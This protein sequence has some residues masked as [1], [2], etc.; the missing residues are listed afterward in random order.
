MIIGS[1]ELA[2]CG[3]KERSLVCVDCRAHY[4]KAG[5]LPAVS[6][7]DAPYLFR[8]VQTESPDGSPGR[9]RTRNK[10]KE[11]VSAF[12]NNLTTRWI[13][14][15]PFLKLLTCFIIYWALKLSLQLTL[16]MKWL[17]QTL[18]LRNHIGVGSICVVWTVLWSIIFTIIYAHC[19]RFI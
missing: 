13:S 1:R 6:R 5:T 18:S 17:R 15:K 4:A 16:I 12:I 10:A 11:T 19:S 3:P 9:M 14:F 2:P 7:T 8:P